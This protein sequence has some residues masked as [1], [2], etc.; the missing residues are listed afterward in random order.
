MFRIV[1]A[2]KNCEPVE[3]KN[4]CTSW[5]LGTSSERQTERVEI[6]MGQQ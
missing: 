3:T 4:I 5:T 1:L 2:G 6:N